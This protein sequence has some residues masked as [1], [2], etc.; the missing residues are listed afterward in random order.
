MNG[1]TLARGNAC[2]HCRKL[3]VRCTGWKP[4]CSRCQ[5]TKKL[6]VYTE[7]SP[8]S[9]TNKIV[10]SC[11]LKS[12]LDNN[13]MLLS[14]KHNLSLILAR[15]QER[16]HHLGELSTR[17][18]ITPTSIPMVISCEESQLDVLAS[19]SLGHGRVFLEHPQEGETHEVRRLIVERT[20]DSFSWV[21]G[22]EL[23]LSMSLYLIGIFLPYRSHFNFFIPLPYFLRCLSLPQSHPNSIH[24]SLRNACHLAA[25]SILGGRWSQLEPHFAQITRQFLHAALVLPNPQQVIHFLWASSLMASYLAR[26]RRIEESYM[27]ITPASY[28][29]LACGLLCTHNPEFEDNYNPRQF[30]LPPPVT[31]EE[32]LHRIWLAHSVFTTDQS[33]SVLTGIPGCLMCNGRWRPS[34]EKAEIVYSWFKVFEWMIW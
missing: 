22:Q 17:P 11:T 12:Q 16:I 7:A 23:P 34:T 19:K 29:A 24:P 9:P 6:C 18:P 20:L 33:L 32:A 5:R 2:L 27:V 15:L 3:K 21:R 8:K 14:S 4:T 26:A 31:E 30:L 13:K 10:S 1:Y 25:C 28:M